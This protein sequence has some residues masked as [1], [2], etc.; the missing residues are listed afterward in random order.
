ME[1]SEKTTIKFVVAVIDDIYKWMEKV[2]Q[3]ISTL[4]KSL[5]SLSDN[6]LN[7]I[8]EISENFQTI[9]D[10]I[11]SSRDTQF[12]T[13]FNMFSKNIETIE[14]IREVA[15]N[16]TD[17]QKAI[18]NDFYRVLE[19]LQKKMYYA[20]YQTLVSDLKNLANELKTLTG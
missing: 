3:S 19:R 9:T 2:T 1:D 13:V 12:K 17:Q 6:L 16:M 5:E 8:V 11:R 20:D 14:G 4:N 15:L 10:L 7:Q 18:T